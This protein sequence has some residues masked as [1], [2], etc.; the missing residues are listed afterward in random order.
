[1][2]K[3]TVSIDEASYMLGLSKEAIRKRIGRGS[4]PATKD[5][6]GRWQVEVEDTNKDGSPP[7][8]Q[9]VS[10]ALI[11][12]LQKENDFLKKQLYEQNVIML[13]LAENVKLL[14]APKQQR[15]SLWARLFDRK[16]DETDT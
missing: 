13:R 12:Q 1:M 8:R 7:G 4:L 3:K 14:E 10:R 5:E 15:Q 9:D 2:A 11:E 6:F 16:T